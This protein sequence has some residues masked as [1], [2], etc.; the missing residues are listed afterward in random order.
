M[1]P[2]KERVIRKCVALDGGIANAVPSLMFTGRDSE[3]S[4]AIRALMRHRLNKSAA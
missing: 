2:V 1:L 4:Y 3:A